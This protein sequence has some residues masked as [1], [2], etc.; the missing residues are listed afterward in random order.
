MEKL[1]FTL[2]EKSALRAVLDGADISFAAAANGLSDCAVKSAFERFQ[3]AMRKAMRESGERFVGDVLSF[4]APDAYDSAIFEFGWQTDEDFDDTAPDYLEKQN[5][6]KKGI[7]AKTGSSFVEKSD[8]YFESIAVA[9]QSFRET[10]AKY[11]ALKSNDDLRIALDQIVLD[12][13]EIMEEMPAEERKPFIDQQIA[14]YL[15]GINAE[16]LQAEQDETL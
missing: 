4:S 16:A 8:V 3:S 12:V 10:L 1:D 11:P 14:D 5:Q 7:T 15:E 13:A 9:R 2:A 6:K